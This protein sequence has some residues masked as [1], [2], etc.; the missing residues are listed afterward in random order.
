MSDFERE[1]RAFRAALARAADG[2]EPRELAIPGAAEEPDGATEAEEKAPVRRRST[3]ILAA[4]AA[5][6][7]VV[8]LGGVVTS[9][10]NGG[11][12]GDGT[13]ASDASGDEDSAGDAPRPLG[14]KEAAAPEG[15]YDEGGRNDLPAPAEGNR[16]AVRYDIAFQVPEE[17]ADAT[18]PALP[19][20][21]AKPGDRWDTVPRTPYVANVTNQPVPSIACN[22]TDDRDFPPQFGKVPFALWQPYVL[23]EKPDKGASLQTGSLKHEGWL[24]TRVF[25]EDAYATILTGPGD[26]EINSQIKSSLRTTP[27]DPYGCETAS[28]LAEGDPVRPKTEPKTSPLEGDAP[29][30]IAICRYEP[31]SASLTGSREISGAEAAGLVEAIRS[32]P[33]RSGPNTPQNCAP[34]QPVTAYVILRIFRDGDEPQDVYVNYENCDDHG[35]YDGIGVHELTAAACRPVFAEEPVTIYSV[36]GDVAKVCLS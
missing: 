30:S 10:Q 3:W 7:A 11:S 22:E 13:V 9:L 1:E 2:F 12:S 21:I 4:A 8:G 23:I 24:L 15:T 6:V 16:W 32:A 31:S 19:E 14:K 36:Q 34:A 35:F 28:P 18:A 17:W 5:V 20:C 26:D 25:I 29:E 33:D 27:K